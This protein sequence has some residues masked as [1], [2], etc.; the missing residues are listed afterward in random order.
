MFFGLFG[1][2]KKRSADMI[3]AARNGDSAK[4]KKLVLE[5]ASINAAESDSGDTPILAAID[6][7][8][9]ET[10][11]VILSYRPD[12]TIED[13]NGNSPLYL[14]VTHGDAAL[15]IVNLLLEAGA[16]V[17]LG[18][19]KGDNAGATPL[20][21]ACATG[22]NECIGSLLRQ[23]ASVRK[24][25]PSG[26]NPLHT[27]AIGG[28]Q[29]TIELLCKAGG[30]VTALNEDMR[31]PLHNC[32]ITGKSAV[33]TALIQHGAEIDSIDAE[34]CTP[35]LRAVMKNHAAVAKVLLNNG[36][37]PDF[38]VR[39]D[40]TPLYPLFV[41]AMSGYDNVVR[42][43]LENGANPTA[44]VAGLPSPLD[45]AKQNGHDASAKLIA[46]AIK[47]QKAS[48]G[49]NESQ[50]HRAD[51]KLANRNSTR[52]KGAEPGD[53]A[54]ENLKPSTRSSAKSTAV[55]LGVYCSDLRYSEEEHG[56]TL[57]P[58][59]KRARDLWKLSGN[60]P[61]NKSYTEACKLLSKWYRSYFQIRLGFSMSLAIDQDNQMGGVSSVAFKDSTQAAEHSF[62]GEPRL[63]SCNVV[64]VD[65]RSSTSTSFLREGEKILRSPEVGVLA[66]YEVDLG[67]NVKNAEALARIVAANESI[68]SECFHIEI[69]EEAIKTTNK[70]DDGDY[71]VSTGSS[72]SGGSVVVEVGVNETSDQLATRLKREIR[73]AHQPQSF[74]SDS[75]VPIKK[76]IMLASVEEVKAEIDSGFDVNARVD[77]EPVLRA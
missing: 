56:T 15:T 30:S 12:L 49:I 40:D 21:I 25:L 31:T 18:P 77:G 10:A 5:G 28:D 71:I 43:L 13:K 32:G 35:L 45:A 63:K 69:L 66:I 59:F 34:G 53:H 60:D 33:A 24:Q 1:G 20:H 11:S 52:F 72:W 14:A 23:G 57:P 73:N 36:A 64:F 70:N 38:V 29:R 22:A 39:T 75:V 16:P 6:K 55:Q 27:A 51:S 42:A 54:N 17:D 58:D 48:T 3:A 37:D 2:E 62:N 76:A 46:A 9:W 8:Q 65:F 61:S 47:K 67:N 68:I 7:S 74:L 19:K 41:A 44:N 50:T 26:A 4:V